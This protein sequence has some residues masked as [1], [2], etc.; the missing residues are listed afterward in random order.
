MKKTSWLALPFICCLLLT[1]NAFGITYYV[2][3]TGNDSNAGTLNT[4]FRSVQKGINTLNPGDICIIRGGTYNEAIVL[5]RSGTSTAPIT[6]MNYTGETVTISSGTSRAL[7]I[8]SGNK[9][10][11]TIDGLRFIST[12]TVF[13]QWGADYTL[14]F[15]DTVWGG[16][17]DP[18]VGNNGFIL[19]NCYIE[20]AICIYGHYNLVENCELNGKS[21]WGNG[22]WERSAASH[23]NIY[24]KNTIYSYTIRGVWSMQ[25]T[26]AV[27]I[28]G[29]TVH[30]IGD[31]GIDCD[32]ATHPVYNSIVRGNTVYTAKKV[33]ISM[34]NAFNSIV[35][36]NIV[37]NSSGVGISYINY[38][39]EYSD[40]EYRTTNT[41]GL[42][43]NN[44]VYNSLQSGI[45]LFASSGNKIYN[46]T[47]YKTMNPGGFW[48]GIALTQT[49]G[50]Y[51]SN[52]DIKNNIL[53]DNAPYAIYIESPSSG[54]PNVALNNNLY[55]NSANTVTHFLQNIGT[56]SLAQYQN[57]TG[58]DLNSIFK[59]PGF[60]NPTANDFHLSGTSP[61]VNTGTTLI[62]VSDDLE[63]VS[64][65]KGAEY[66]IGAY[67]LPTGQTTTSPPKNLKILQ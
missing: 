23:D 36:K 63:S 27:L 33:G 10:Y 61:A 19:R 41:N 6:I 65:P 55:Y 11:Y 21:L 25:N 67:E 29:N 42:I 17:T 47:V 60:V 30:D 16:D 5:G 13:D 49:G 44:L 51:S 38:G 28:E 54:L 24:K 32:G 1:S 9:H 62:A 48:G 35:E 26:T 2:S 56:L 57:K 40:A 58:Q 52:T 14:D 53:V 34:E 7:R 43:R 18:N 22:I 4:P 59:S 3:T 64:R 8:G 12:H 15:R 45:I 37:Y 46:N 50:Y 20:G 66:D 39:T 31:Q